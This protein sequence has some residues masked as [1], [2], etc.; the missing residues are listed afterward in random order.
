MRVR[1]VQAVVLVLFLL[2]VLL[3]PAHPSQAGDPVSLLASKL[4][5]N[6][7]GLWNYDATTQR[8][9]AYFP[10]NPGQ[11]D[12]ATLSPNTIYRINVRQSAIL[13]LSAGTWFNL[14]AGW[15]VI[16][17]VGLPAPPPQVM[18]GTTGWAAI[19]GNALFGQTFRTGNT[20]AAYNLTGVQVQLRKSVAGSAVSFF[21]AQSTNDVPST[22]LSSYTI[23][24]AIISTANLGGFITL[25]FNV[26]LAAGAQ[27]VV[28]AIMQGAG[29]VYW[30]YATD[31]SIYTGGT[32]VGSTDA[33]GSWQK[34]AQL[35][36][37]SAFI[38]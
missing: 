27:Y 38:Q 5:D 7:L 10:N 14:T 19:T 11:S 18:T 28:F 3:L 35:Q 26:T 33:G 17:W 8:W 9:S 24:N 15:N 31:M 20:Q 6:L 30:P 34:L 16:T 22:V 21:L 32:A 12:L 23:D 2:A 1:V 13:V 25:P 4:G 36:I 29:T 37:F